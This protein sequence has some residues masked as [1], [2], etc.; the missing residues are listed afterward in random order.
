LD[1]LDKDVDGKTVRYG[2]KC[3][4]CKKVL[5]ARSSIGTGH[6]GRHVRSCLRKQQAATATSQTNLHFAPDGRVAHFEYNPAVARTELCRLIARLDLP[7][8][9][10]ASIEFEEY[11]RNAHNPRFVRV[12]RT[13]TTSDLDAYFITKV[14]EVKSLLS[15]A[16]CVCL[17]SDIWSG[18]AK[19]DYLNVVVHFVTTDWKLEKRIIGFKLIDCS[20][21]GVNI[22]ERISLVLADYELTSKVLSVTLDNASANASAM[23]KL[24]PSLSSYVGSSLLHQRCA[25]YII[26]LIVKSGLKRLDTYLDDF[27]IAIFFLNSSNQHIASFKLYCLAAGVHPRKFGLDMNIRWNSTYLML[28][29]LVPYKDTFSVFIHTNYKSGSGT[30]LTQDHWYVAE[31]I[32]KFLE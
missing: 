13:T 2:A 9:L 4:F 23:D 32:L 18:N 15:E 8:S 25:C 22:A 24:T 12:S 14:A 30:L 27:R 16:S 21:S 28:K 20:H 10:G 5:T 1:P 31:H 11:I 29:H 3:K 7:L 26:N 19:E 6:L 17:I